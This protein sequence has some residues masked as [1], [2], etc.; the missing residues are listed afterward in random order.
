M[1]WSE[2]CWGDAIVIKTYECLG[3]PQT[4]CSGGNCSGSVR[5]EFEFSHSSP[6]CGSSV[7]WCAY[8][9]TGCSDFIYQYNWEDTCCCN[10]PYTPIVIDIAGD[11]FAMTSGAEGVRFNFNGTGVIEKVSWTKGNSDDAFLVL[12]RN[13]N[14]RIDNGSELFGNFTEQPDSDEPNG[15]LALAEFD[16]PENGGNGDGTINYLDNVFVSLR[17]WQDLNHNGISEAS[18]LH[19]LSELGIS[20]FDLDY[21]ESKRTDEHGNQFRYRAKVTDLRGVRAGLW[22]WDIFL[23]P[24][25]FRQ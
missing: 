8:P 10:Q 25:R 17:L 1:S 23:M 5:A 6:V 16:K 4:A 15:F 11:G 20:S 22:A 2:P 24:G 3:C 21:K 13:G 14:G 12:D 9:W 18:E 19:P 7:D